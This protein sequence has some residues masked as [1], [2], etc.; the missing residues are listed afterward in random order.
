[1]IKCLVFDFDGVLIDSNA[2]KRDAYFQIF[3]NLG[4]IDPVVKGCLYAQADGNRF[5][6]IECILRQLES[7]GKLVGLSCR[8]D[9]VERFAQD[10]NDICEAYTATCPELDGVSACLQ[11]L[12]RQYALYINSATLEEPLCRVVER[13]GWSG[14]F[15]G[16]FGSPRNKLDNLVRILQLENATG[17]EVVFVGD[18]MRDLAAAQAYGCNFVG[19]RNAYNDFDPTDLVMVDNWRELESVIAQ[20]EK[21]R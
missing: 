17:H 8:P 15:R 16:V 7:C 11:R 20:F 13:R 19:I 18:G 14:Y 9:L 3:A 1:M 4:D 2:I 21:T 6:V 5:Q 12:V 10:Y